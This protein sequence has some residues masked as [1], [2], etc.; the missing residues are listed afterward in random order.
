MADKGYIQVLEDLVQM[1]LL[2]QVE[3]GLVNIFEEEYIRVLL[4]EGQ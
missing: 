3:G 1:F 2:L 4:V